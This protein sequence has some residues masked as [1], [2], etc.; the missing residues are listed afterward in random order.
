MPRIPQAQFDTTP[1]SRVGTANVQM[2]ADPTGNLVKNLSNLAGAFAQ[3]QDQ[4]ERT[5]A[6]TKA[7]E[8]KQFYMQQKVQYAAALDTVDGSG[9]ANYIDPTDDNPDVS[10]RRRIQ[11]PIQEM[12]KEMVDSYEEQKKSIKGIAREDIAQELMRGYVGDDLMQLQ[13]NTNKAINRKRHQEVNELVPQNIELGLSSLVETLNTPNPNPEMVQL[14]LAQVE[15]K[16]LKEISTVTNIVG[17]DGT[18]KLFKLKDRMYA[19][20]AQQILTMNLNEHTVKTADALVSRIKDPAQKSL[21][22]TRLENVKRSTA[23]TKSMTRIGQTQGLN[24]Q[25]LTEPALKDHTYV[26]G[27]STV[28]ETLGMYSDERYFPGGSQMKVEAAT[29]LASTLMAK[30]IIEN[31]LEEDMSWVTNPERFDPAVSEAGVPL[32]EGFTAGSDRSPASGMGPKQQKLMEQ[33][34]QELEAQGAA[35][36]LGDKGIVESVRQMTMQKV[37]SLYA[38]TRDNIADVVKEK[39]KHLPP[40]EQLQKIADITAIQSGGYPKFV[41][42]REAS[43]FNK[44]FDLALAESPSKAH[45]MVEQLLHPA[46]AQ[47][48]GEQSKRRAMMMDIAGKDPKRAYMMVLADADPQRQIEILEGAKLFSKVTAETNASEK[49]FHAA[50]GSITA[51]SQMETLR[52]TSPSFYDGIKQAVFFEA[53][54]TNNITSKDQVAGAVRSAFEKIKEQY[55]FV[56]SSDGS[57]MA[58]ILSK[59]APGANYTGKERELKKGMDVALNLPMLSRDEKIQLLRDAGKLPVDGNVTMSD[60]NIDLIIR[61]TVKIIPDG[62]H[63]NMH[64][65]VMGDRQRVFNANRQ[66]LKLSAEDIFKYGQEAVK[67]EMTDNKN[68]KVD[69]PNPAT[70]K[71]AWER[72]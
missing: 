72:W 21:A 1:S 4:Q 25:I 34:Q 41:G 13:I 55:Q 39:Y 49:S 51:T 59:N 37:R 43:A 65:V 44:N 29:D 56:G 38:H 35:G 2:G 20:T 9:M 30:K 50:W 66:M 10:K 40:D 5:E 58:L 71:R 26:Q 8:A 46:G 27:W 16:A 32:A 63:P 3:L 19:S 68:F 53:A 12:Y 33:I 23:Y 42:A 15:N 61:N 17:A 28:M 54:R 70:M 22:M 45:M 47:W 31:G 18:A 24:Q 11:R 6:Y 7:N 52:K 36:L 69:Y 60:S 67:R 14:K 64:T 57:S 62:R 48:Q